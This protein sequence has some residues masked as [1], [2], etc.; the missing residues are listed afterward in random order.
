MK[1]LLAATPPMGWMSWN[2]LG[3]DINEPIIKETADALVQSGM[4]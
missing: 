1:N 4:Q 2:L 3:K